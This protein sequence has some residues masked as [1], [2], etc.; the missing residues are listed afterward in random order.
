[1]K[2]TAHLAK[3]S[4]T[5]F[6]GLIR[7][8]YLGENGYQVLEPREDLG[9][10]LQ[11]YVQRV[12]LTEPKWIAFL[13]RYFDVDEIVNSASSFVLLAGIQ[14]RI[15]A[16]TFGQAFHTIERSLFEPNFGLRVTANF[17]DSGGLKTIDTRTLDTVTRQ[18]RTQVSVGSRLVDFELDLDQE[19]VRKLS[20][21]SSDQEFARSMSGSDSLSLNL[22]LALEDLPRVLEKLLELQS[23]DA[24]K[25]HFGFIDNY[26]PLRKDDPV[27]AS[28]EEDLT[29]KLT[30]RSQER[31][32][33]AL[34]EVVNDADIAHYRISASYRRADLSELAIDA[35]YDFLDHHYTGTNPLAQVYIVPI[36]DSEEAVGY[37]KPLKEY[38]VCE[39]DRGDKTYVLSLGDW[40]EANRDYVLAISTEV[41]ALDDLTDVLS[42]PDWQPSEDEGE[43]N[44]RVAAERG[45]A[46]MDKKNF[47]IGG[48]NQKI[49]ICDL[50]TPALQMLCV[51]KRTKS[52]TLS[53]L[54]SQG[55]VSADLYRGEDIYRQRVRDILGTELGVDIS[56]IVSEPTIVYAIATDR[57]G[58][59]TDSLFFFSKVNLVAHARAIRRRGLKIGLLKIQ[60]TL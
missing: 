57:P 15:F 36:N 47:A 24:Y 56:S 12:K 21:K 9:F 46:L 26:H 25:E 19:W 54:F 51:K 49:E 38:I 30:E 33:L 60:L 23:S 39:L 13:R 42:L 14:D 34:P 29:R 55:S 41:A 27:V 2:L 28:L 48:P 8:K 10:P 37:R 40:F 18:Q 11:A 32:A 53:H 4:I 7:E 50:L 58:S 45:W 22:D 5:D 35:L 3:P 6:G 44:H 17:V 20:G 43:Y 16:L 59:V 31:I 52:A 1:M